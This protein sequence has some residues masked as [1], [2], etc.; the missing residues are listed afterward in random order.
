MCIGARTTIEDAELSVA[1]NGTKLV[2]G[3]DCMFSRGIHITTTD[4]HSIISI[5]TGKRINFAKN[6][7]IGNHVWLGYCV[8]VNKGVTIGDNSVVASHSLVTKSNLPNSI[9]AGI[10]AKLIKNNITWNRARLIE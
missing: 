3:K 9:I 6:V 5:E 1:E 10:P 2:I 4:S 7:I 8:N